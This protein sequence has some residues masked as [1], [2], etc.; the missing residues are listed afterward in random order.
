MFILNYY[1][2][3]IEM[4]WVCKPKYVIKIINIFNW[5]IIELLYSNCTP[6]NLYMFLI[7]PCVTTFFINPIYC[8]QMIK[9]Y[10]WPKYIFNGRKFYNVK[11]S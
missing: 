9:T 7:N 1:K 2:D 11:N 8:C 3:H 10:I 6:I 5:F 4:T